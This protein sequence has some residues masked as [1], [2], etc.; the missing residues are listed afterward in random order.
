MHKVGV[1]RVVARD[2]HDER[3][4]PSP[5]GS[6]RLLPERGARAGEAGGDHGVEAGDVHPELQRRCR[7]DA[8]EAAVAERLLQRAPLRGQIARPIRGDLACELSRFCC[9][10]PQVQGFRAP[11][12]VGGGRTCGVTQHFLGAQRERFRAGARAHE[13]DR[14][15]ALPQQCRHDSRR[16]AGRRS[17]HR[18]PTLAE[19]AGH[20]RGLPQRHRAPT[21]WRTVV[22]DGGDAVS[23][24]AR[25]GL[26]GVG[27]RRRGENE[28]RRRAERTREPVEPPQDQRDI[29]AEHT[30]VGVALV[31]DDVG[32]IAEQPRPRAVPAE[33]R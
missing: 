18:R 29:R 24:Q 3:A 16:I 31:D 2:E 11:R 33:D 25:G 13:R 27:R 17:P 14:V 20:E 21:L 28:R 4:L 6:A 15:R 9:R 1:E 19:T 30:A 12:I 32:E 10:Q 26:G 23:H 7:G 5:T 22:C 8:H